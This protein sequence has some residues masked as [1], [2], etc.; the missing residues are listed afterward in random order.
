M[1]MR[2]KMGFVNSHVLESTH[3]SH[4]RQ[5]VVPLYHYS[6]LTCPELQPPLP[7]SKGTKHPHAASSQMQT[8]HSFAHN[9]IPILKLNFRRSGWHLH[10]LLGEVVLGRLNVGKL[11]WK[12][13]TQ[14]LGITGPLSLKSSDQEVARIETWW[15]GEGVD[16]TSR[17]NRRRKVN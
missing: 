2:R 10:R 7:D 3:C 4:R 14:V 13:V 12:E 9:K 6:Q 15:W 16:D 8:R 11:Y 1:T 17:K 5:G